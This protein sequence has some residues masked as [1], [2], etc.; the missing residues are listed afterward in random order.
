MCQLGF[1]RFI[2]RFRYHSPRSLP[3]HSLSRSH[4]HSHS[5]F[6]RT[7]FRT[8]T[9]SFLYLENEKCVH[10]CF[11]FWGEKKNTCVE[12]PSLPVRKCCWECAP[13]QCPTA[14][15]FHSRYVETI[16][17]VR[18]RLRVLRTTTCFQFE[19]KC[20]CTHFYCANMKCKQNSLFI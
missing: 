13:Q 10:E 18:V 15:S 4:S 7:Q 14:L 6:T 12:F 3:G 20:K 9:K 1:I 2:F 16:Q 5:T 11:V 8:Q 17:W 19:Y